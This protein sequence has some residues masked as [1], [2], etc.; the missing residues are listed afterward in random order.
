MSATTEPGISGVDESDES[1]DTLRVAHVIGR[2]TIGGAEKHFVTLLNAIEAERRYAVM[3]SPEA[4]GPDLASELESTIE[5]RRIPVRKRSLPVD[6]IR[7]SRFFK[8]EKINVVHT[9][10]FWSNLY[11]V[12]AAWLAGVPVIVTTEHGENRWKRGRHRWLERYV[13]SRLAQK[14]FCVSP[15]ILEN[16]RDK[17]GVPGEKLELVANGTP[18]PEE[19]ASSDRSTAPVIGSI[20]RFVVQKNF[21]LFVD[22]VE[23]LDRQGLSVDG[24]LAGDGPEMSVIRQRAA[25]AG[26]E[27]R[28]RLPGFTTDTDAFFRQLFCY[29]VTSSEEGQPVSLLEAMS[30]GLPIVATDVGAISKTLESGT[31]GIIVPPGD[32]AALADAVKRFVEDPEFASAC[33]A[34]AR[35]RVE[36][37]FSIG[38][39]ASRYGASYRGILDRRQKL[40]ASGTS[41]HA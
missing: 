13:I 32:V 18:L 2:L 11:G 24:L 27:E 8:Q 20:G 33:G 35:R 36:R 22:L 40:A 26:V 16:R 10:M 29:V 9:H 34:A 28:I 21:P 3:V 1:A 17:D 30:Y 37:E 7:L 14:R 4:D 38:A 25:D 39:V 6:I 15:V 41:A 31:E 5:L 12:V 19:L 23:A